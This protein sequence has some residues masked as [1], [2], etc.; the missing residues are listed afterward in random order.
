VP[1]LSASGLAS[2]RARIIVATIF[3]NLVL[4]YGV[5]YSYAVALWIG[6]GLAL[7]TP[8]LLWVVAPRHPN[9]PPGEKLKWQMPND[10]LVIPGF[11]A[12]RA[13]TKLGGQG[14]FCTGLSTSFIQG[15]R[16]GR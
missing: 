2:V 15:T 7:A 16:E 9:P 5:W 12:G 11:C 4:L 8:V 3:L 1:S 6:L 14:I 13:K 10:Q